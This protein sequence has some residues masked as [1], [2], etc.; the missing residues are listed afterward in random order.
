LLQVPQFCSFCSAFWS[1]SGAVQANDGTPFW[2]AT[3]ELAR[4]SS[5]KKVA[6]DAI[7]LTALEQS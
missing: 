3:H 6:A 1:G 2:P 4:K 5:S 7:P